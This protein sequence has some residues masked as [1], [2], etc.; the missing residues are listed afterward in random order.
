LTDTILESLT[1]SGWLHQELKFQSGCRDLS[2]NQVSQ[3]ID[4]IDRLTDLIDTIE[5]SISQ[6]L[7][8]EFLLP[9]SLFALDLEAGVLID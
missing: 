2:V 5:R 3:S 6:G 8:V 4:V 9:A 1:A 7:Q